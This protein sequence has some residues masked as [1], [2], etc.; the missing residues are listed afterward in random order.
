MITDKDVETIIKKEYFDTNPWLVDNITI[1]LKYCCPEC[2]YQITELYI[3]E[4]HATS[5]HKMSS[6]LFENIRGTNEDINYTE[7]LQKDFEIPAIKIELKQELNDMI[8]HDND[9]M[10]ESNV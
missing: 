5:D 6:I 4:D 10:I 3:F 1:L 9:I 7:K 8:E 2:D